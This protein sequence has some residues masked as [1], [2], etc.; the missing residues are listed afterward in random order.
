MMN[1]LPQFLISLM[2]VCLSVRAQIPTGGGAQL[3]ANW[4]YDNYEY[5]QNGD[6]Q[7]D[8][9]FVTGSGGDGYHSGGTSGKWST[10]TSTASTP[11]A[12]CY[13]V[14]DANGSLTEFVMVF[15]PIGETGCFHWKKY[16]VKRGPTGIPSIR[17]EDWKLVAEGRIC[18]RGSR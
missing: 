15:T 2:L 12:H 18:R 14:C 13:D 7:S 5:D 4:V 9:G 16:A 10:Q 17:R 3:P 8:G 6:A 11:N 1:R